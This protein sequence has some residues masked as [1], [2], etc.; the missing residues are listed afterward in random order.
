MNYKHQEGH[1]RSSPQKLVFRKYLSNI[2]ELRVELKPEDGK[3]GQR[4]RT[5][6]VRPAAAYRLLPFFPSS[7]CCSAN[8]GTH[9]M[10][11][12]NN[13]AVWFKLNYSAHSQGLTRLICIP[14]DSFLLFPLT[15][16]PWHVFCTLPIMNLEFTLYLWTPGCP[17]YFFFFFNTSFSPPIS[18]PYNIWSFLNTF[19]WS[20]SPHCDYWCGCHWF[21]FFLPTKLSGA[22]GG[23]LTFLVPQP[24]IVPNIPSWCPWLACWMLTTGLPTFL[25]LCLLSLLENISST[26]ICRPQ[27]KRIWRSF[28]VLFNSICLF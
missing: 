4:T 10:L 6:L 23:T 7:S 27:S 15:R 18:S 25:I 16:I 9:H 1:K 13:V 11:Y 5:A 21:V 22:L 19:I 28:R 26:R 3:K 24:S 12:N 20:P 17:Q 8:S 2:K 14:S